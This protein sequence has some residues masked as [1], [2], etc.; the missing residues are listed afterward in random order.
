MQKYEAEYCIGGKLVSMGE[1][2]AVFTVYNTTESF[3]AKQAPQGY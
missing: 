1:T 3:T 2:L